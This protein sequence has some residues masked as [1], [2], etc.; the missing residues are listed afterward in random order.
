MDAADDPHIGPLTRSYSAG[1]RPVRADD[2][3]TLRYLRWSSVGAQDP[4][5][6]AVADFSADLPGAALSGRSVLNGRVSAWQLAHK[7]SAFGAISQ[8]R[9]R[10]AT[11]THCDGHRPPGMLPLAPRPWA[12]RVVGFRSLS[13]SERRRQSTLARMRSLQCCMAAPRTGACPL[14]LPRLSMSGRLIRIV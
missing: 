11:L 8:G 12:L 14:P 1:S 4:P 2:R 5:F 9:R 3:I 10:P 7:Y 6:A 13:A